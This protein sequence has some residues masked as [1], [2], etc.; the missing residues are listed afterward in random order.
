LQKLEDLLSTYYCARTADHVFR[1]VTRTP[2]HS[3]LLDTMNHDLRR[4]GTL[5]PRTRVMRKLVHGT[6]HDV[7]D[8]A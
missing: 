1:D 8:L 7:L 2:L 3:Q 6:T 4:P 5:V